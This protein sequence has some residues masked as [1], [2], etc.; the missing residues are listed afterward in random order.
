MKSF[1]M[2]HKQKRTGTYSESKDKE[3]DNGNICDL[4]FNLAN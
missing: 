4:E 1:S 3:N 2:V